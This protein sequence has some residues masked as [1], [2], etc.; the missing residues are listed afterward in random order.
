MPEMKPRRKAAKGEQLSGSLKG[1]LAAYEKAR[2]FQHSLS[3]NTA[4]RYR[5][6]LQD[7]HA[8]CHRM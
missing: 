4:Y 8:I 3:D 2:L 1:E 6:A 7:V 5:G